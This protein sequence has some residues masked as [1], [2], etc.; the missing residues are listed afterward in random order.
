MSLPQDLR[1]INTSSSPAPSGKTIDNRHM[2]PN[3]LNM[4]EETTA[5]SP[6]SNTP[7]LHR[8]TSAKASYSIDAI[9]G[10]RQAP[11]DAVI[12]AGHQPSTPPHPSSQGTPQHSPVNMVKEQIISADENAL[13]QQNG[14]IF[15]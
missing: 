8:Q 14:K 9:L 12:A 11:N 13:S 1:K 4:G 3:H 5:S 10:L 7:V 15:D 6:P 2:N